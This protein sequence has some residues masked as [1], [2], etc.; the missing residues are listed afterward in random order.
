MNQNNWGP[1]AWAWAILSK[2]ASEQDPK[3]SEKKMKLM[4]EIEAMG[5]KRIR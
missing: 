5:Y 2:I 4:E 1:S 3:Y